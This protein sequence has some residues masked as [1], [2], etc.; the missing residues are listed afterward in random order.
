MAVLQE[1]YAGIDESNKCLRASKMTLKT[2]AMSTRALKA[3]MLNLTAVKST[4]VRKETAVSDHQR[5]NT[6]V[7]KLLESPAASLALVY[8]RLIGSH[9]FRTLPRFIIWTMTA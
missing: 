5:Q 2:L 9:R 7:N 8:V 1:I 3:P 4:S 6:N